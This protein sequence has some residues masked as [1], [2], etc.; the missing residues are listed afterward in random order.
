MTICSTMHL[1]L[2]TITVNQDA[3]V[4]PPL[5][6]EAQDTRKKPTWLLAAMLAT[7]N[8]TLRRM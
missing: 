2:Q 1:S 5:A 8:I 6:P 3:L 4:I 7:T